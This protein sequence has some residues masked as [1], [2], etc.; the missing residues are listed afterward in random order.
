M[1][2]LSSGLPKSE[3]NKETTPFFRY[4]ETL[5]QAK[6]EEKKT[7]AI[8]VF[9]KTKNSMLAFFSRIKYLPPPNVYKQ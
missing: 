9:R 8:S 6:Q 4:S 3:W 1:F 7:P 2:P 5:S